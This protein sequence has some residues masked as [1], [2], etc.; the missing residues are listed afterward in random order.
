MHVPY[1][2][3]NANVKRKI[4]ALQLKLTISNYNNARH[5]FLVIEIRKMI[6]YRDICLKII[7][8]IN[9]TKLKK[10]KLKE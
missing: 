6:Q 1:I 7:K 5:L 4:T 9:R 8:I 10:E 3:D 2:I